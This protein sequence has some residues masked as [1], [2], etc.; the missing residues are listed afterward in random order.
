MYYI[1]NFA[2]FFSFY[3]RIFILGPKSFQFISISH[4]FFKD[5]L[6]LRLS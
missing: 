2:N 6:K 1:S 3:K 5:K 4:E